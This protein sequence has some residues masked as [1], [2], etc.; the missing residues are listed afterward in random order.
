[1]GRL[2]RGQA[3][4]PTFQARLPN[5]KDDLNIEKLGVAHRR[6]RPYVV[7]GY[8]GFEPVKGPDRTMCGVGNYPSGKDLFRRAKDNIQRAK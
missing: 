8:D 3:G 5:A 6:C 1:M 2:E 7:C 4:A